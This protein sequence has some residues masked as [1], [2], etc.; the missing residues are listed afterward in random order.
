MLPLR[1]HRIL[2]NSLNGPAAK[3]VGRSAEKWGSKHNAC[4][5]AEPPPPPPSVSPFRRS[6]IKSSCS[7]QGHCSGSCCA[8]RESTAFSCVL[9]AL[10]FACTLR[11]ANL[12]WRPPGNPTRMG[13]NA[14]PFRHE[15]MN[16]NKRRL[17]VSRGRRAI[18]AATYYSLAYSHNVIVAA[19]WTTCC[20]AM[21]HLSSNSASHGSSRTQA[22][23]IDHVHVTKRPLPASATNE[24]SVHVSTQPPWLAWLPATLCSM[25][26]KR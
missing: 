5:R 4:T 24:L 12:T 21:M 1:V 9:A 17:D 2:I 22:V 15:A 13:R 6:S 16:A 19:Y 14:D 20:D 18:A 3:L 8:L 23:R 26:H 10:L 7:V 25:P 11:V